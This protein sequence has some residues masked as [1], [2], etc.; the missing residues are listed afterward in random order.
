[1]KIFELKA[2]IRKA[3]EAAKS[4][5]MIED[6][7]K[8]AS[9]PEEKEML[10]QSHSAL[11]ERLK[12]MSDALPSLLKEA[13]EEKKTA[14]ISITVKKA[15]R[16]K[17]LK[18]LQ[19]DKET[20]KKIKKA[21]AR[22]KEEKIEEYKKAGFFLKTAARLFSKI[23]LNLSQKPFFRSIN[24][25]LR[26]A[27]MPY[28]L[29]TYVS[30]SFLASIIAF[31]PLLLICAM[32]FY[33]KAIGIIALILIPLLVPAAVFSAALAYPKMEASSANSKIEEELPFAVIHMSAIAGSGVEPT[34]VFRI[35]A[36]SPEYP[37]ISKE[38]KKLVNLINFYG[39]DLT[40]ALAETAKSTSS[41]KL[42]ELLN[43]MVMLISSGGNMQEYLSKIA[44]DTLLDYKLKR[45]RFVSI[46]E[47]YADIYT[48]LM[49]AAPLMFMLLL[50]MINLI[51]GSFGGFNAETLAL[52][53][54]G[55]IALVNM[56]FLIFLE[57]SV[58]K[59]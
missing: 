36:K 41:K 20:L 21:A 40:T 38:M 11:I 37:A 23:S 48:G 35:L 53:G 29:P 28:L 31:F 15:D 5:A 39:Y 2:V 18:E 51:G 27:N 57:V 3:E 32:L 9:A 58:P 22:K 33:I 13:A 55:I 43:G 1:M 16:E 12:T 59:G 56:G 46:A 49:I 4:M 6:E 34:R 45:K 47:T 44:S 7:L 14:P 30:M 24:L 19:I 52:I 50:M 17:Y 42:A 25:N 54:I 26:K 8:R 10:R